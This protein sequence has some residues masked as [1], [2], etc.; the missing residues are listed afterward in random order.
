MHEPVVR[1]LEDYLD[2]KPCPEVDQHLSTC[3]RCREIVSTMRDQS[4]LLH[5]LRTPAA[6]EPAAGFYGR[7]MNRVES[8]AR[9]SV[10]NLF[11][12]S[13]FAKRLAYA[14]VT[15][16]VLLGTFFVSLEVPQEEL[17]ASTPEGIFATEEQPLPIET[18]PQR[19]REAVL[20]TLTTY[21][22]Y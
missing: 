18:D 15:F 8:Q 16:L 14:S 2:G 20:V 13:P 12:E 7:V 9:P 1:R 22:G 10:W 19:G 5:A 21:Q 3:R 17:A 11:G 6:P 4:M